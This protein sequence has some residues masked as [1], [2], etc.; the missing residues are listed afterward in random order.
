MEIMD[1]GRLMITVWWFGDVMGWLMQNRQI[2]VVA[3][4]VLEVREEDD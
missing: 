4:V 2:W 1:L 3:L